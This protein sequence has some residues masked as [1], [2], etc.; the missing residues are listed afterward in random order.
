MK[1][2]ITYAGDYHDFDTIKRS[3]QHAG[4]DVE[5]KEVGCGI[6]CFTGH[7]RYGQYHAVFYLT[8]DKEK[9]KE[10]IQALFNECELVIEGLI[11]D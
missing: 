6:S 5:Y 7:E 4:F 11:I 1:P 10:A 9:D 8:A 2:F 3:F